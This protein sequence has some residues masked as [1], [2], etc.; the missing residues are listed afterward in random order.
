MNVVHAHEDLM[1]MQ[2]LDALNTYCSDY[3]QNILKVV[4]GASLA[5]VTIIRF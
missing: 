3:K 4:I 2:Q 1:Y 5:V